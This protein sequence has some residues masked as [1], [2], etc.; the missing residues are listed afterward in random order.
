MCQ[1]RRNEKISVWFL[2][3]TSVIDRS[4]SATPSKTELWARRATSNNYIYNKRQTIE[5]KHHQQSTINESK[6]TCGSSNERER[7]VSINVNRAMPLNRRHRR[8]LTNIAFSINA[9]SQTNRISF[10]KQT[11][12]TMYHRRVTRRSKPRATT[13]DL[14]PTPNSDDN[15]AIYRYF[16]FVVTQIKRN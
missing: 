11:I 10:Q 5:I 1:K 2:P 13:I 3:I 4:V 7:S 14:T 9:D 8:T 12:T 15:N 16:E 6:R